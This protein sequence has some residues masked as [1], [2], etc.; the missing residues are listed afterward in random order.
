MVRINAAWASGYFGQVSLDTLTGADRD[1]NL[2]LAASCP[3][4]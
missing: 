2:S 3:W 4:E 1:R